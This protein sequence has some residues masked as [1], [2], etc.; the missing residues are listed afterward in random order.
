MLQIN[1]SNYT[2][3]L[4]KES[5]LIVSSCLDHCQMY[6]EAL[7]FSIGIQCLCCTI[8]WQSFLCFELF[9]KARKKLFYDTNILIFFTFRLKNDLFFRNVRYVRIFLFQNF[10]NCFIGTSYNLV[11]LFTPQLNRWQWRLMVASPLFQPFAWN[12]YLQD[13]QPSVRIIQLPILQSSLA[14]RLRDCW[15]CNVYRL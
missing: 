10:A 1:T 11:P 13:L 4:R 7:N 5:L 6:F 14:E 9:Q 12:I 2:T 3:G 8:R 15:L